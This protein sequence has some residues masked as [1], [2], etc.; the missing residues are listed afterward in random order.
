MKEIAEYRKYQVITLPD[1]YAANCIYVNGT[2]LHCSETDFPL[3][4]NVNKD[5]N[6][7]FYF[8]NNVLIIILKF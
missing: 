7:I 5:D 2:L 3:S 1:N 4:S 6:L 8:Q